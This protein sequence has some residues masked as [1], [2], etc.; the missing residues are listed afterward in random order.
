[1][2]QLFTILDDKI[3]I[4]KAVIGQIEGPTTFTGLL[5]I[6]GSATIHNNLTVQGRLVVDVIEANQ[7][8]DRSSKTTTTSAV[9]SS[10]IFT[11]DEEALLNGQG[12]TWV[13]G[14]DQN[15]LAYRTGSR[16]GTSL[17]L[18]LDLGRSYK[19]DNIDVLTHNTLG[20]S[21]SRSSLRQLGPLNNLTVVGNVEV[22][23]FFYVD[24]DTNRIG[25]DTEA[26]NGK[27]SV[28]D[29]GAEFI[30]GSAVQGTIKVGT[31]S[32]HDVAIV[33]DDTTRITIKNSGDVYVGNPNSR[34]VK[35]VVHGSIHAES[36]IS[37]TKIE[38]TDSVKFIATEGS[39]YGIGLSWTGTGSPKQL[40]L[41]S[42]PD[43][44]WSS[45]HFDLAGNRNY[46]VNGKTV[47]SETTLGSTVTQSSL[48]SVGVLNSLAVVGSTSLAALQATSVN[49]R[50]L[51]VGTD[52]QVL[53]VSETGI[54]STLSISLTVSGDSVFYAD[55]NTITIGAKDRTRKNIRTFGTLSVNVT[56]PDP[57]LSLAVDGNIGFAGRKFITGASAPEYGNYSI[58][59]ICWNTNPMIGGNV[60]WICL[61]P[62]TPGM[63]SK[64]GNIG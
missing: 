46:L 1:M 54:A 59:D 12:F 41:N 5:D 23:Q 36:I 28:V 52:H 48:T 11:A 10:T 18:D 33:T 60:G 47:L 31:Y 25:I 9:S 40:L 32:S 14:Q 35:F 49:T 45:E 7:V 29:N 64:F 62:G 24:S 61:S 19:I 50:S 55:P 53:T 21:I 63:W 51:T 42:G 34:D 22:G 56:N 37:E 13:A 8:I 6:S 57:E 20:S 58:G 39:S 26:P 2:S 30:V 17:N 27:L 38:R 4:N 44:I 43:R 16:L 3:V 15:T